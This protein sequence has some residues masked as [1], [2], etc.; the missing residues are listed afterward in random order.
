LT[1]FHYGSERIA[2]QAVWYVA[3]GSNLALDRFRSYLRGGRPSGGLRPYPGC[4]DARDPARIFSLHV[5]GGLVF[6]GDSTVWGGGMAFFDRRAPGRVACR[7]YLI[8]AEQFADVTAQEMRRPSGGDF[9]RELEGLLTQVE[10]LQT[11]GP[12]HYE[13]IVRLGVYEDAPLLTVT[14]G[15]IADLVPAAPSAAYMSQISTGLHEAHLWGAER[16]GTYLAPAPGVRRAWT[17]DQI[18]DVARAVVEAGPH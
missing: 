16:I 9:A 17:A 12:G 8:S 14:H 3:Y 4:R 7:A 2:V 11:L 5:P 13:T 1:N 15:D 6:A 18:A 10:S